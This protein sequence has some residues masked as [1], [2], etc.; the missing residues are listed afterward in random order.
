MINLEHQDHKCLQS[1][2]KL[3]KQYKTLFMLSSKSY[4]YDLTDNSISI[5][6][7]SVSNLNTLQ[8]DSIYRTTKTAFILILHSGTL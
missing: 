7:V 4:K 6:T 1:K 2:K 8:G 3:N 5:D